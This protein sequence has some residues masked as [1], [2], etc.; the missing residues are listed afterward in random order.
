MHEQSAEQ[1]PT[2]IVLA[3][4]RYASQLCLVRRSAAVGTAQGQWSMITGYLELGIDPLGQVWTELLEELGFDVPLA[5]LQALGP[6][7]F[8]APGVLAERHFYFEVTVD[9]SARREPQLDGS[10]LEH[11]GAVVDVS[12][13]DA[14]ALCR[15]GA[16]EDAKTELAL[17][18]L[19]EQVA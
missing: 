8:P 18:R 7:T 4:V 14:L 17:R 15:R 6:S 16:I 5:A 10:A 11:F 9:P 12:L 2:E 13:G 1:A 3:V 19:A